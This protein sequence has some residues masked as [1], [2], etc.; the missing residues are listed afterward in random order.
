MKKIRHLLAGSVLA[1]AGTAASAAPVVINFDVDAFGNTIAANTSITNQYASLGVTFLGLENGSAININAAPDPDGSPTPSS[2][3]ALTNC[4]NASPGCPGNRADIVRIAFAAPVSDVS[5]S[6][7]TLG[8]AAV[9]FN[10]YDAADVLLETLTQLS[11]DGTYAMVAFTA[12]GV[13]RIDALQ[14]MDGWAW[15]L[16]NLSFESSTVPEPSAIALMLA[17]GLAA[18]VARRRRA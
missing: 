1:L 12:S 4:S 11:P 5:L 3:N 7:N 15:T 6:L 10:L 18:G 2:P 9:T 17:A 14:P 8:P 16:D 13:A